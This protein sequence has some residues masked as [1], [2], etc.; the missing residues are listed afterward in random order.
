MAGKVSE[1]PKSRQ[2]IAI[3]LGC[4]SEPDGKTLLM[5]TSHI[6]VTG[7]RELEVDEL[8]ALSFLASVHSEGRCYV[9]CGGRTLTS[10]LLLLSIL[11]ITIL[12]HQA[13]CAH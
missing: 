1:D 4:S 3:T 6:L 11:C 8:E 5:K 9:G 10:D 2:A 13:R 7:Y 12:T